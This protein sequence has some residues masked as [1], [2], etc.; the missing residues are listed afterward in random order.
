MAQVYKV[1][2]ERDTQGGYAATF[3]ELVGLQAHA[4][5]LKTLMERI[6]EAM[7]PSP[8]TGEPAAPPRKLPAG[9]RDGEGG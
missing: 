8:E 5:S 3:P 9:A 2:I 4:G 1:V 7:A 6:R